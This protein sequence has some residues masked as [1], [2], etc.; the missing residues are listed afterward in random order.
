MQAGITIHNASS[1]ADIES[2]RTLLREYARHLNASLGANH[3]CLDSYEEELAGLPGVYSPP[4]GALLLA[5]DG[6]EPAGCGALKPL[7]PNRALDPAEVACEMKRL[8]VRPPFRARGLGLKL[9]QALLRCARKQGYTA[10]YLDTIPVAMQSANRIYKNLGFEQVER[11]SANP[12]LAGD[13]TLDVRFYRRS[14]TSPEP[15]L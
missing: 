14:L 5:S 7:S 1:S 12:V 8:W 3:I 13:S 9:A 4:R 11:Y 15:P 10:I 2:I 6:A